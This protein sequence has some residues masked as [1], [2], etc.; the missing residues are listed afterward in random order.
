MRINQM[1]IPIF[2]VTALLATA[3]S[4]GEAAKVP[5][6][7]NKNP[8]VRLYQSRLKATRAM[9]LRSRSELDFATQQLNRARRLVMSKAVSLE[10][11]QAHEMRRE[12]ASQNL[13]VNSALV[14]EAEALVA[15]AIERT[16]NGQ[17]MPVVT[18]PVYPR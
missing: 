12:Q 3:I 17:D 18:L 16:R 6:A 4:R 8:Y 11:F 14:E 5:E 13:V 15:I 7:I 10:E 9:V 2:F 1:L